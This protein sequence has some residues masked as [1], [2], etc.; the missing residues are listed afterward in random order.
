MSF[1]AEQILQ[2]ARADPHYLGNANA[3]LLV[4]W[5]PA[6]DAQ[7]ELLVSSPA[8]SDDAEAA[9]TTSDNIELAVLKMIVQLRPSGF[10]L[11]P[12]AHFNP[13]RPAPWQAGRSPITNLSEGH[14]SVVLGPVPESIS[15]ALHSEWLSYKR[16]TDAIMRAVL[17]CVSKSGFLVTENSKTLY[18]L[19]HQWWE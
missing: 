17:P 8:P 9:P 15:V 1:S 2:A 16:A 5:A 14:G 4:S 12:D 13:D 7:S 3:Q 11:T 19:T 18:K 10:Y 6:P